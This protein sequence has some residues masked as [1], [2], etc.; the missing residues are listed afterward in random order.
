[1]SNPV[2]VQFGV[3]QGSILGP[4]LFLLYINDLPNCV[5]TIPRFFA[6]DTAL[7]I[8][9]DIPEELKLRANSELARISEW[10]LCN[11]LT[12]NTSKTNALF[13]TLYLRKP[14]LPISF[15]L[16]H[17]IIHPTSTARYLGVL[18]DD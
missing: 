2:M 1:M 14:N 11:T 3:P 17:K 8:T 15:T 18:L 16:N 6:D 12:L 4:L 10:M 5:Q 13:I 7:L 9:H